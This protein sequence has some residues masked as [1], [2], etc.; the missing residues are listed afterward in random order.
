MNR[1]LVTAVAAALAFNVSAQ[2]VPEGEKMISYGRYES[3]KKTLESL[4]AKDARANYDLGIA[5]LQLEDIAG[6]QATFARFPEDFFNQAGTARV[7]F[8]QGKRDEA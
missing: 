2:S 8:K 5:Q 3:A 4:A 6:A 1:L 7:L